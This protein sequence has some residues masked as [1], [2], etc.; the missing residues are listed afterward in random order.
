MCAFAAPALIPLITMAVSTALTVGMSVAQ[1]AQQAQTQQAALNY[2]AQA[3]RNAAQAAEYQA[4]DALARGEIAEED[5]RRR[6][7][8]LLGQHQARFAA[9]GSDLLGSPI[10]MLGDLA[11]QG[12]D[13]ALTLRYDAT[14]AAW[15][16]RIRASQRYGDAGYHATAAGNVNPGFGI[17]R[18]LLGGASTLGNG[19]ARGLL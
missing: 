15:E 17:A 13:D 8:S 4:E 11:A 3:A 18:S 2:Q 7:A 16:D 1:Q 19:M 9:Q 10:D 6:T 14:R 5:Q 12:E